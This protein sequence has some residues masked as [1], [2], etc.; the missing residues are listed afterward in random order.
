MYTT[1][2]FKVKPYVLKMRACFC[3][4]KYVHMFLYLSFKV[5]NAFR[6]PSLLRAKNVLLSIGW[7]HFLTKMVFL[8]SGILKN[9]F[10]QENCFFFI[11]FYLNLQNKQPFFLGTTLMYM[12]HFSTVNPCNELCSCV[13]SRSLH[14]I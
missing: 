6:L 10:T 3:L 14:V 9:F 2:F 11:S 1:H 5:I 12:A 13:F 4:Q 7:S 8:Q